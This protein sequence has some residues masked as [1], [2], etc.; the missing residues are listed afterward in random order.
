MDERPHPVKE[1][2]TLTGRAL[3]AQFA[4]QLSDV[5]RPNPAHPAAAK[6]SVFGLPMRRSPR[7]TAFFFQSDLTRQSG[8][9]GLQ[10]NRRS[11]DPGLCMTQTCFCIVDRY[12]NN[13]FAAPKGGLWSHWKPNGSEQA[14][15]VLW[16]VY[17]PGELVPKVLCDQAAGTVRLARVNIALCSKLVDMHPSRNVYLTDVA[18]LFP[19]PHHLGNYKC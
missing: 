12:Q 11:W 10:G 13:L 18:F 7:S 1:P 6:P 19:H 4:A 16:A 9:H 5:S 15:C 3:V 14:L 2:H 8:Y 17:I